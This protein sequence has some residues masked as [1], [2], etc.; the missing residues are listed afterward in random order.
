LRAL[1]RAIVIGVGNTFGGDDAVGPLVARA[2][3]ERVTDDVRLLEHEG[4]PTALL[5]EWGE[6]SLAVIVDATRGAGEPGTVRRFDASAVPVPSSFAGT[7]TH[8]FS[9]A[10]A[11]ELGR[12]LG[13]LPPRL[14]VIGVEGRGFDA[15]AELTPE[16]AAAVGPAGEAVLDELQSAAIS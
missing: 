3:R 16:V 1:S 7:T 9:L 10:E 12:A 8:A 6:A 13:R 5:D 11:I 15:G 2:L 14:I 4:E